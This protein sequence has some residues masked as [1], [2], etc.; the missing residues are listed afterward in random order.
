MKKNGFTLVELIIYMAVGLVIMAAIYAAVNMAQRSSASTGRKVL[1]TQDARM[2]LDF[3]AMDI[4]NVSYNR[5][6][7]AN[8]WLGADATGK[9]IGALG[10]VAPL[11]GL[12]GIQFANANTILVQ[13]DLDQNGVI[14][15]RPDEIIR[16]SYDGV[17]TIT[18]SSNWGPNQAI[19][20]RDATGSAFGTLVVNGQAA[21]L[22]LPACPVA[23]PN[24]YNLFQ[25]FNSQGN[26]LTPAQLLTIA[27]IQSIRRIRITIV[28]QTEGGPTNVDPL[29][30]R[31][32]IMTHS[33]DV[34]VKNHP[35]GYLEQ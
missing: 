3:M 19:L 30:G 2:V 13:M 9:P 10:V 7:I 11:G 17:D 4:R 25:Y 29:T 1:T 20:G 31:P 16:Y 33:T 18:R 35:L 6:K 28:A 12:R 26:E 32:R 23:N 14:A 15:N 27:G 24:C 8:I 22:G 34:L 5:E 21:A